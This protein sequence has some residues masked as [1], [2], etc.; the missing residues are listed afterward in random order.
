MIENLDQSLT[1]ALA[2]LPILPRR[3]LLDTPG[4]EATVPLLRGVW[5]A[6]A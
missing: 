3:M 5:G 6:A 1:A 4:V 2:T